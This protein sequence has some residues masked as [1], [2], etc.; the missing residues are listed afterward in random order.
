[1]KKIKNIVSRSGFVSEDK[2]ENNR[3]LIFNTNGYSL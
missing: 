3:G 2:N 1:M